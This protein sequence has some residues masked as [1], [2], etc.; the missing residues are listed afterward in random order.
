ANPRV[1][2]QAPERLEWIAADKHP[3][4]VSHGERKPFRPVP[5]A[6][7]LPISNRIDVIGAGWSRT[8]IRQAD[9]V[10]LVLAQPRGQP[11]QVLPPIE[12]GVDQPKISPRGATSHQ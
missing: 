7:G 10:C 5:R 6:W 11:G 9:V 8:K 12:V 2:R 3:L 1:R 4:Q